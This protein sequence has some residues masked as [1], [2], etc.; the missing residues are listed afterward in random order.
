MRT[1]SRD[2]LMSARVR[3]GRTKVRTTTPCA[4]VASAFP[5]RRPRRRIQP[6]LLQQTSKESAP[7]GVCPRSL[8]PKRGGPASCAT[9]SPL[10]TW[11]RRQRPPARPGG[12]R[13][14]P[15]RRLP[16][17]RPTP[18]EAARHTR[19]SLPCT[20]QGTRP[21][22]DLGIDA[23]IQDGRLVAIWV[24]TVRAADKRAT[25]RARSTT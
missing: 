21:S 8:S 19:R 14:S 2:C 1:V 11:R 25:F 7:S 23:P 15:S 16:R 10:A 6:P 5:S 18:A 12:S 3:R 20:T 22:A 4:C 13:R 9:P 24:L 17:S